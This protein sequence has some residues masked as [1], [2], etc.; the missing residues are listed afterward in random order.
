M[1]KQK[2]YKE[3][4]AHFSETI[5]IDPGYVKGYNSIGIIMAR[6]GKFKKAGDFFSKALQIDSNF[7]E[8]RKNLDILEEALSSNEP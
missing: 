6:Q 3:A 4:L 8:A 7:V 1:L 5:K 2:K